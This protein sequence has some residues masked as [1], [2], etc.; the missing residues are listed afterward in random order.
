[1]TAERHEITG[2][3]HGA[4]LAAG[5]E[6]AVVRLQLDSPPSP[7]WSRAFC[8]HL[9]TGL[10]GHPAVGDLRLNQAIQGADIVLDGV[11]R[12]E[13]ELLG[14]VLAQAIEAANRACERYD[15]RTPPSPLPPLN[16]EPPEAQ[17]VADAVVA[18]ARGSLA[19]S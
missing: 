9:A 14:P 3:A 15:E 5:R 19:P 4:P 16:M 17:A 7:R 8:G 13:A 6:G 11:E 12:R 10:T 18:S 2:A 1:V